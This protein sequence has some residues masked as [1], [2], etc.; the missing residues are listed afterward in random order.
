MHSLWVSTVIVVFVVV[1][2]HVPRTWHGTWRTRVYESSLTCIGATRTVDNIFN[3]R[4]LAP[5]RGPANVSANDSVQAVQS[6]LSCPSIKLHRELPGNLIM[7]IT[8]RPFEFTALHRLIL[9]C[10]QQQ[11]FAAQV[12]ETLKKKSGGKSKEIKL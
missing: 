11:S 12:W 2:R 3:Y 10:V 6:A 9:N 8:I 1:V 7:A 4:H 5:R